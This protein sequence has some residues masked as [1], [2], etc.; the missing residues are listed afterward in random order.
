MVPWWIAR[1]TLHAGNA[2]TFQQGAENRTISALSTGRYMPSNVFSRASVEHLAA[3]GTAVVTSHTVKSPVKSPVEFHSQKKDTGFGEPCGS[4]C[5]IRSP[6]GGGY[7]LYRGS[8]LD[9]GK[10][11][12]PLNGGTSTVTGFGDRGN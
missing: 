12:G 2:V 8:Y 6:G 4:G 5:A 11:F 3:I 10:G 7:S 1:N 9:A